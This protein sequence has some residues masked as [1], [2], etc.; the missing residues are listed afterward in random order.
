MRTTAS[1]WYGVTPESGPK[2]GLAGGLDGSPP[3]SRHSRRKSQEGFTSMSQPRTFVRQVKE[4]LSIDSLV[5]R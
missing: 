1:W 2:L 4:H 3:N 5:N